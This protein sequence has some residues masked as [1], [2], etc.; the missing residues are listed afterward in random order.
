M[1]NGEIFGSNANPAWTWAGANYY[2]NGSTA[3]TGLSN[4]GTS[5]IVQYAFDADNGKLWFGRNG[6]WYDSSWGTGGNPAIGVNP[7]V[8]GLNT[9]KTYLAC[10]SFFNGSARF[11]FGQKPFKFSPPDGFQ[12]INGTNILSE[13]VIARPDQYVSVTT[14]TGEN[15]TRSIKTGM[16]PDLVW[17]KSRNNNYDN[18]LYDSVRGATNRI[19]SN[20]TDDESSFA[21]GL[22][23]LTIMDSL[24][25]IELI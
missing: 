3:G 15:N 2:F 13:T 5:D 10:A 12:P 25:V 19:Y 11:N 21:N 23:F 22:T 7:T 4:H 9:D 1:V 24:L 18:E 6:V 8:S 16:K 17:F 20:T 14:Y